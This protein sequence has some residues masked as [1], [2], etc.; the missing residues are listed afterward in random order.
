MTFHDRLVQHT[1]TER[2]TLLSLP[3]IQ[4]A[5]GGRVT[6]TQYLAYLREAYHHVK[7]TL[8]LLMACGSRIPFSHEWLRTAL[9]HYI[10]EETGHQEWILSDITQAGG[11]AEAVR[12]GSGSAA[13]EIM[14][15]YAYDLIQRKNPCGF[16]GMVFVLEGTSVQLATHAAAAMQ[17]SLQLPDSAFT[18]LTS[19]GN[20]DINHMKF[21]SQLV[22]QLTLL[23]DQEAVL[24]E[25]SIFY[26]LYSNLFRA[27]PGA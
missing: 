3:I 2:A 17:A 16:L 8:P 5:L 20:L 15:A 12:Q 13:T 27:L 18:Y 23:Q 24:S 22:N 9:A 25:A 7:H 6:K 10:E 11:D 26:Q 14:V 21:F 19:H 4:S 1:G